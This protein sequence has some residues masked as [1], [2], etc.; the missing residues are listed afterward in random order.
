MYKGIR[1]KKRENL[2]DVKLAQTKCQNLSMSK[3]DAC[4]SSVIFV[5][6]Q[7]SVTCNKLVVEMEGVF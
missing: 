7:K 6:Y 1:K 5:S 3:I 2:Q 4:S